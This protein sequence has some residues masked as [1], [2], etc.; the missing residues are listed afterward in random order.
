MLGGNIL[1]YYLVVV[2]ECVLE[3]HFALQV[4]QFTLAPLLEGFDFATPS[5]KPLVMGEGLRLTVEK[6]APLEVLVA[7]LLSAAFY[8]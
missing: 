4:M 2:E 8:S 1:N 3:C 6:S 5:N 7:L